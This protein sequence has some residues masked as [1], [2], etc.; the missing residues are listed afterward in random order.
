MGLPLVPH[1]RPP[2]TRSSPASTTPST[3]GPTRSSS[4]ACS[5]CWPPT[6]TSTDGHGGRRADSPLPPWRRRCSSAGSCSTHHCSPEAWSSGGCRRP[7]WPR[8]DRLRLLRDLP[9][10]DRL[11]PRRRSG[12]SSSS[13]TSRTPCTW[14]TSPSIWRSQPNGTHWSFWPT[15][16]VQAGHHL[17]HRRRQL[18]PHRTATAALAPTQRGQ[19]GRR[20]HA[21]TGKGHGGGARGVAGRRSPRGVG[22]IGRVPPVGPCHRHRQIAHP[23]QVAGRL[24]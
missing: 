5:D 12:S 17:R 13:A 6:G 10:G 14:C 24:G 16:L 22:G 20:R 9:E 21:G 4:A 2:S 23:P 8:R 19:N 3:P 7:R 1:S 11:A 18:V 15:E